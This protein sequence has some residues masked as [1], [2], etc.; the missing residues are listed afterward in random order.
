[1]RDSFWEAAL[2]RSS[3]YRNEALFRADVSSVRPRVLRVLPVW[4]KRA[5]SAATG[6]L[7][8]EEPS[9]DEQPKGASQLP[10]FGGWSQ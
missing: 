7:E 1:M 6:W 3:G 4:K 9:S 2:S 8:L 5:E 10:L